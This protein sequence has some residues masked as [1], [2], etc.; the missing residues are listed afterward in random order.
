MEFI[1]FVR[2]PFAVDAVEITVENM[3]EV[4]ELIGDVRTK[5]EV[6]YIQLDRRIIPNVGRAY[7][8]WWL[9]RLGD[10]YRC[11]APK[12]FNEQFIE[13]GTAPEL[14]GYFVDEDEVVEE[15]ADGTPA[16]GIVRPAEVEDDHV[17]V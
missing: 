5:G 15:E 7:V 12:V 1:Q 4:A 6:T 14:G 11:Y 10:N 3:E 13:R 2:K 17:N 9:T 16:H 8:G